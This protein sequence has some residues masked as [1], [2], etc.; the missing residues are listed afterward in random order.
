MRGL[1]I[2][3]ADGTYNGTV[4]MSSDSSKIS[5]IRVAKEKHTRL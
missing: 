3:L 4:T 2:Y 1:K 5:A